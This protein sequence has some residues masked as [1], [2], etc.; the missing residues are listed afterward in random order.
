MTNRPVLPAPNSDLPMMADWWARNYPWSTVAPSGSQRAIAREYGYLGTVLPNNSF[1]RVSGADLADE[2]RKRKN[3]L[4][5]D[6]D[7]EP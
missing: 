6:E 7:D 3:I 2:K 5:D 1:G 4:P